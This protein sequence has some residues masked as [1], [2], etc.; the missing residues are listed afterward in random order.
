MGW[1][2]PA[3]TKMRWA[4]PAETKMSWTGPAETQLTC[5]ANG[6]G[7]VEL[8]TPVNSILFWVHYSVTVHTGIQERG[9]EDYNKRGI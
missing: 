6:E 4:G 3:E 8:Q 9:D 1:A 2:G 5:A 7:L